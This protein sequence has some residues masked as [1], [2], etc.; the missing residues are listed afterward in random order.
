MGDVYK[1]I[2]FER[3]LSDLG[4]ALERNTAAPGTQPAQQPPAAAA[5]AAPGVPTAAFPDVKAPYGMQPGVHH[6]VMTGQDMPFGMSP[7]THHN[8]MTGQDD[9]SM[10][11]PAAPPPAGGMQVAGGAPSPY[12]PQDLETLAALQNA[13]SGAVAFGGGHAPPAPAMPPPSPLAA[14]LAGASA[15]PTQCRR[16]RRSTRTST[17]TRPEGSPATRRSAD[18]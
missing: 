8:V 16:L 18:G 14:Q 12:S 6:N 7:N 10:A 2:D 3:M 9:M 4:Q 11:P 13:S 15:A 5:P 1:D 17:R